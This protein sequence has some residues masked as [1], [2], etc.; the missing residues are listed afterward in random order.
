MTTSI[1][2]FN[3]TPLDKSVGKGHMT[4]VCLYSGM[5][6]YSRGKHCPMVEQQTLS[7][8]WTT[9]VDPGSGQGGSAQPRS[10][11][12]P[13]QCKGH[14]PARMKGGG[15]TSTLKMFGSTGHT[16]RIRVTKFGEIFSKVKGA[17]HP[18]PP[19]PWTRRPWTVR[20]FC[21]G[22][23]FTHRHPLNPSQRDPLTSLCHIKRVTG[24]GDSQ[25]EPN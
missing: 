19:D 5:K 3:W 4:R 6:F 8:V 11:E 7:A 9:G 15:E 1:H 13:P 12:P 23:L 10:K 24:S 21:R 25:L 17:P 14:C 20:S 18:T 22:E 2:S 16:N